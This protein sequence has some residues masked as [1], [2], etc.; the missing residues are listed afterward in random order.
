MEFNEARAELIDIQHA[1]LHW[2][3]KK[4]KQERDNVYNKWQDQIEDAIDKKEQEFN[5]IWQHQDEELKWE[6]QRLI[7]VPPLQFRPSTH[8][9]RHEAVE[10]NASKAKMFERAHQA[11][12]D[13][14]RQY[15]IDYHNW[16][17][18]CDE[19]RARLLDELVKN[20]RNEMDSAMK[21]AQARID[22]LYKLQAA[23]DDKHVRAWK[24]KEQDTLK[25]QAAE[26]NKAEHAFMVF[27]KSHNACDFN[28]DAAMCHVRRIHDPNDKVMGKSNQT[29]RRVRQQ[30]L[31]ESVHGGK[32]QLQETRLDNVKAGDDR[33]RVR[34]KPAVSE[35]HPGHKEVHE[36]PEASHRMNAMKSFFRTMIAEHGGDMS[37]SQ[38]PQKEKKNWA[39]FQTP[40]RAPKTPL[41]T[42]MAVKER[43]AQRVPDQME[44]VKIPSQ[45]AKRAVKRHSYQYRYKNDYQHKDD[46][47]PEYSHEHPNIYTKEAAK[48]DAVLPRHKVDAALG[49]HFVNHQSN[50]YA[51]IHKNI[52]DQREQAVRMRNHD[53][54]EQAEW[55][56]R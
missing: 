41:T 6:N 27:F 8:F 3:Q 23:E 14:E 21:K 43:E 35:H 19:K 45:D 22:E 36:K 50:D 51:Q 54:H 5:K 46:Q 55:M 2:L 29:A 30:N 48:T 28:L 25:E 7:D 42:N 39:V 26:L 44:V 1:E 32:Y 10:K 16:E 52:A 24:V 40:E 31:D 11:R 47:R 18:R 15:A 4:M 13:K 9:F 17:V 53:R 56:A 37:K 38:S 34:V 49:P 33:F 20:Q 12:E